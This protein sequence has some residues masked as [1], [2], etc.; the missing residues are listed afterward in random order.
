MFGHGFPFSCESQ[1]KE[2]IDLLEQEHQMLKMKRQMAP[3]DFSVFEKGAT[4][5]EV[6]LLDEFYSGRFPNIG[7]FD[8]MLDT[9]R[10]H[11]ESEDSDFVE[12]LAKRGWWIVSDFQ[13]IF[14]SL[15][16]LRELAFSGTP[17]EL[18]EY[19][20]SQFRKDDWSRLNVLIDEW[21]ENAYLLSEKD[22]LL[23]VIEA[24]EEGK[25]NI[26]IP[27]LLPC[28]EGFAKEYLGGK[29]KR[30]VWKMARLCSEE[31]STPWAKKLRTMIEM[32]YWGGDRSCGTLNRHG[33]LHGD[34]K[35]STYGTEA[36]S[37]RAILL[38]HTLYR[39]MSDIV[40]WEEREKSSTAQID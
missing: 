26:A 17:E 30:P 16:K 5:Q 21:W 7:C 1:T 36:N 35:S 11:E 9:V 29:R 34:I 4:I 24:H 22:R 6:R 23:N 10:F 25:Y 14:K 39:F 12:V 8:S 15:Q 18:D 31:I 32:V 20:C 38:L 28:I 27:A 2:L 37:L 19:I 3:M 40:F 13:W 33:I